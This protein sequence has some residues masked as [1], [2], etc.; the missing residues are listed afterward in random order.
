LESYG[1]HH[2]WKGYTV[3]DAGSALRR[4]FLQLPDPVIPTSFYQPFRNVMSKSLQLFHEH[5]NNSPPLS[6]T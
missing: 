2:N 3:H 5:H 1:L 4:Y 6:S